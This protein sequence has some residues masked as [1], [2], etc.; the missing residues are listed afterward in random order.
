MR[1]GSG[2]PAAGV[3]VAFAETPV[4]VGASVTADGCEVGVLLGDGVTVGVGV[5][6]AVGAA[7]ADGVAVGAE[8][9][10]GVGVAV[11]GAGVA[12]AT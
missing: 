12:G 5:V 10:V 11:R 6:V 1:S 4:A 2:V 9:A 8:V 3:V 7:V